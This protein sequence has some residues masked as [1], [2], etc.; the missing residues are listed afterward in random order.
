MGQV[1]VADPLPNLVQCPTA[2]T[3]EEAVQKEAAP[4]QKQK[5]RNVINLRLRTTRNRMFASHLRYFTRIC[6][7]GEKNCHH[8]FGVSSFIVCRNV[9]LDTLGQT[10]LAKRGC[11]SRSFHDA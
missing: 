6:L 5:P 4:S 8:V 2:A 11:A 9:F 10:K 7:R 1:S 3:I